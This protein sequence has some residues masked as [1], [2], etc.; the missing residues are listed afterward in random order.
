MT[1]ST[2]GNEF[3]A[4]TVAMVVRVEKRRLGP[5]A[6]DVFAAVERGE[7]RL[8]VPAMVFAE[9]MYLSEKGRITASVADLAAYMQ[10]HP[11][12]REY[13]LNLA[14]VQSASEI[15]DVPELH[16]RLIAGT[17]RLLG[18]ELVSTDAEIEASN[19][20]RTIW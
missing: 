15:T 14:V 9:V 8:H 19:F 6:R 4:D 1:A 2:P 18:L 17:A 7:A 10:E 12:C 13:P 5:R 16:D 11:N 20:V 3:V